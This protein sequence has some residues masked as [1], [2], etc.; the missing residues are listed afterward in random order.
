VILKNG[1]IEQRDKVIIQKEEQIRNLE[2]E[3][4]KLQDLILK[5]GNDASEL[6]KLLTAT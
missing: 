4:K 1:I 2:N 6:G 5:S 3:I